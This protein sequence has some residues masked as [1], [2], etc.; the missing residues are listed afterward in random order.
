MIWPIYAGAQATPLVSHSKPGLGQ[1]QSVKPATQYDKQVQ[2][3]GV[4]EGGL[5][6]VA[7]ARLEFKNRQFAPAA[8]R[9]SPGHWLEQW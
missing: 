3:A 8:Y 6:N 5:S 9:S 7:V 1:A 4:W 2:G